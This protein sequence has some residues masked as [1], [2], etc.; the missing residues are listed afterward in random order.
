M[1][2]ILDNGT[3]QMFDNIQQPTPVLTKDKVHFTEIDLMITKF[4]I[5]H[6]KI[7][8]FS[9]TMRKKV[10]SFILNGNFI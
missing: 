5:F 10:E 9:K 3:M 1:V 7:L 6:P 8:Y 4:P 2:C